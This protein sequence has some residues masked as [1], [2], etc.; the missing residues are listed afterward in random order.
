MR[1]HGAHDAGS[2]GHAPWTLG[3][4]NT[5]RAAEPEVFQFVGVASAVGSCPHGHYLANNPSGWT[6]QAPSARSMT[7]SFL[8]RCFWSDRPGVQATSFRPASAKSWR[9]PP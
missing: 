7:K 9:V 4:R 1:P 6:G 3:T 5:H 2:G 8:G